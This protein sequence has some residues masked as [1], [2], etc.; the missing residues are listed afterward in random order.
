MPPNPCESGTGKQCPV[1]WEGNRGIK[2]H[3]NRGYETGTLVPC[4]FPWKTPFPHVR[5]RGTGSYRLLQDLQVT[6]KRAQDIEPTIPNA[7]TIFCSLPSH[8]ST[9]KGRSAL[10]DLKDDFSR[11]PLAKWS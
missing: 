2:V 10:L 7:Y 5:K 9:L 3:N 6:N 8:S 1:T 11:F 4:H